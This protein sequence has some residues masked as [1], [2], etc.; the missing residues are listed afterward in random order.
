MSKLK[1]PKQVIVPP[2]IDSLYAM[3]YSYKQMEVKVAKLDPFQC[4]TVG[5]NQQYAD[6]FLMCMEQLLLSYISASL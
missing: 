5:T 1:Q 2:A 4:Y 6:S 3:Q